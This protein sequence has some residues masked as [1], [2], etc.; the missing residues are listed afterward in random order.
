MIPVTCDPEGKLDRVPLDEL[1]EFQ[2]NLKSLGKTEYA[3]LAVWARRG[4][5][6]V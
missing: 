4:A 3:K 6:V 5:R 2:G 1:E